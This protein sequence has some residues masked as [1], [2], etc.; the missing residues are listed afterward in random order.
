MKTT[1]TASRVFGATTLLG[2]AL[3]GGNGG[4][5]PSDIHRLWTLAG[6]R[7]RCTAV[8]RIGGRQAFV[9]ARSAASIV[10]GRIVAIVMCCDAADQG[11][12]I[13]NIFQ[14]MPRVRNSLCHHPCPSSGLVIGRL[15]FLTNGCNSI[16]RPT[17][18]FPSST[19]LP[20]P[21]VR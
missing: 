10:G 19:S 18:P 4:L 20:Q 7:V 15:L 8:R 5:E 2:P 9:H 17:V 14:W 16:A 11:S 13:Q 21:I 6:N 1:P 3:P 12:I